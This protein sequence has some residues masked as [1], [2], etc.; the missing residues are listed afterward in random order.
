MYQSDTSSEF[1][2][3]GNVAARSKPSVLGIDVS[4]EIYLSALEGK[5][6]LL[7]NKV[8]AYSEKNSFTQ[9]ISH[10][11]ESYRG[12]LSILFQVI[13]HCMRQ[14]SKQVEVKWWHNQN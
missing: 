14:H 12:T 13:L 10:M 5:I 4:N 7:S 6:K 9:P 2:K 3:F 1:E 8:E 11:N